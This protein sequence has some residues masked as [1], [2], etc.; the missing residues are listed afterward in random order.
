LEPNERFDREYLLSVV[1]RD[2]FWI[3][4][5]RYPYSNPYWYLGNLDPDMFLSRNYAPLD[6]RMKAYIKYAHG[7]PKMATDI[8]DNLKGPLPKTYVELAIDD[9][10]GFADFY[11]KNVTAIFASVSDPDLQKQLSDADASAAQA[12]SN[13]RDYFISLRKTATDKFPL[14][15]DLFAQMIKDTE[16]VDMTVAE[17]EAVGKADLARNT[18]ALKTECAAYLP[19]GT[20]TA[21]V[22]KVSAKKPAGGTLAAA[23][24]QLASLKDFIVKNASLQSLQRRV[25]PST[26]TLRSW[27]CGDVQHCTARPQVEQGGTGGLHTE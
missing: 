24:T 16:H 1:D 6:V 8:Q 26:R 20:L 14:G 10:G 4:K 22:A 19:K 13:L 2:L 15:G 17:I 3:E 7:I 27:G 25:H 9:F 21:C 12:M 11:K 5:A 23:R 18:D